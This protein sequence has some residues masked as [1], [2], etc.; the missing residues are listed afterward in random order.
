VTPPCAIRRE[1]DQYACA[2]C[3]LRWDVNDPEP[4]LCGLRVATRDLQERLEN[5]TGFVSALAPPWLRPVT[6]D[7]L[8]IP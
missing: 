8:L 2:K 6:V 5:S 4:P 3:R 7:K 1:Q